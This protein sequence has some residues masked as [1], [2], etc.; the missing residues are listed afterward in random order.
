VRRDN[1]F[2][3]DRA[4][5][6]EEDNPVPQ[7]K[8]QR[9][10]SACRLG[11]G[12]A[13]LDVGTGTGRLIPLILRHIG[14]AGEVCGVDP[15]TGMLEQ[16]KSRHRDPR[17]RFIRAEAEDLPLADESYDRAICYSVYPHFS[18]ESAA[19][20]QLWHVL[21]PGGL[22]IVAHSEG[23]DTINCTHRHAG[24]EV[25]KDRLPPAAEVGDRM[26]RCGLTVEAAR[27]DADF[28]LVVGRKPGAQ[29]DT[30]ARG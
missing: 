29:D 13:V 1:S 8:L 18:D 20:C 5:T 30:R 7:H 28:Y 26:R 24:R 23:R 15:S 22:L 27:D 4:K 25:A 19:L 10:I 12:L 16:A 9:I 17:V 21:R 6:W 11:P 2:F 14:E 3:D